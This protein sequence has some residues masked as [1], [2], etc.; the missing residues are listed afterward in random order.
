MASSLQAG[1]P[2]LGPWQTGEK[3]K[4]REKGDIDA[5]NRVNVSPEDA[6]ALAQAR[7]EHT[8]ETVGIARPPKE[9][10]SDDHNDGPTGGEFDDPRAEVSHEQL[11]VEF[12]DYLFETMVFIIKF[13]N[14]QRLRMDVD[15]ELLY[16]LVNEGFEQLMSKCAGARKSRAWSQEL[17]RGP[18]ALARLPPS[19]GG[20][21][22]WS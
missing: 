1:A 10:T 15:A 6:L 20:S 8:R 5:G 3:E 14:L 2:T 17:Q 13:E 11:A 16:A 4:E 12:E 7:I 21:K 18:P 22:R 9:D 19:V